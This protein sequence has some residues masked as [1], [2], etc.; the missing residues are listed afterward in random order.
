MLVRHW[1]FPFCFFS[2]RGTKIVPS[3]S[4]SSIRHTNR[5]IAISFTPRILL[6]SSASLREG[7]SPMWPVATNTQGKA[8]VLLPFCVWW[9]K[10]VTKHWIIWCPSPQFVW[11]Q[12]SCGAVNRLSSLHNRTQFLCIW[13]VRVQNMHPLDWDSPQRLYATDGCLKMKAF[14]SLFLLL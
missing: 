13:L 14:V 12:D 11:R 3:C 9:A 5:D 2:N 8:R 7:S 10:T 1:C 6:S 4:S